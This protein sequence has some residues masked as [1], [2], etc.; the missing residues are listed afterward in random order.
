[1]ASQVKNSKSSVTKK[2]SSPT[3]RTTNKATKPKR[4]SSKKRVKR[5]KRS[6]LSQKKFIF[7]GV[8]LV[9]LF[10]LSTGYYLGKNAHKKSPKSVEK[11]LLHPTQKVKKRASDI[12]S[13][14][15]TEKPQTQKPIFNVEK[16]RILKRT[17]IKKVHT[18]PLKRAQSKQKNT[19]PEKASRSAISISDQKRMKP[20]WV[21]PSVPHKS[22][23]RE[24][25]SLLTAPGRKAK[26]VII[27]DDVSNVRQLR[28]I[29]SLGI[30]VTP[31]IFPPSA[32]SMK[33]HRLARGL[34]HYMIHLPME[35]GSRQFNRQ[36]KTLKISFSRAQMEAR[37]REIRKLFPTARYIN[38]HTGSVFT[39]NSRAMSMLYGIMRKEGFVFIDSRTI[40]TTKVKKIAHAYGDAY[41]GRDVFIDNIQSVSAIH[42]ALRK[43]VHI[44][45]RKGY[46]IAIGHPHHT[47]MRALATAN[48]IFRDVK[49]VYIDALYQ[50]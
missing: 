15:K 46:A 31:S 23:P 13:N 40:G 45:K 22:M 34:K 35:S 32:L 44:A 9:A 12:F 33:S 38:N 5:K 41:V 14:I 1:M 21:H 27:I 50:K 4:N 37:M 7:T 19:M 43:A 28:Q 39:S 42:R 16:K 10:L 17:V 29:Q 20:V 48:N 24:R 25:K 3:K 26:L 49:V 47:T 2:R 18:S 11:T 36:Y 8:F 30:P 6:P